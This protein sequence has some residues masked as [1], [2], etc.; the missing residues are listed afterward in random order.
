[1]VRIERRRNSFLLRLASIGQDRAEKEQFATEVGSHFGQDREEK[2]QVL[3]E[4]G[5]QRP[6]QRG[7][8]TGF[9]LGCLP[10]VRIDR[11]RNR[12]LLRLTSIGH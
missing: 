7:E 4:V 12:L 11:R 8:G 6:G 3:T 9:Y 10:L 5:S 1:M 2:E